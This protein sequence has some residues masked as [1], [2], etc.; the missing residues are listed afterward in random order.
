MVVFNAHRCLLCP[1]ISQRPGSDPFPGPE[2]N[3]RGTYSI[4]VIVMLRI[5]KKQKF[6]VLKTKN[7]ELIRDIQYDEKNP[8]GSLIELLHA[9]GEEMD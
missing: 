5:R 4:R 2:K 8:P 6:F 1:Q 3:R 9:R 7:R